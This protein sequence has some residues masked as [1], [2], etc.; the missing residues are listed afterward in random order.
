MI[1]HGTV[2]ELRLIRLI[3]GNAG[4]FS[5]QQP[6]ALTEASVGTALELADMRT[7]WPIDE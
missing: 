5:L 7:L 1:P 6:R 2:R 3:G 4:E